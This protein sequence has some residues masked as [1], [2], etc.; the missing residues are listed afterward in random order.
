MCK[1]QCPGT[2]I[3][4][5][6]R[7]RTEHCEVLKALFEDL[8]KELAT[9]GKRVLSFDSQRHELEQRTLE[10]WAKGRNVSMTSLLAPATASP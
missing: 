5:D 10:E 8:E 4:G 3:D 2:A 7:N 6:W 1:G 9:E